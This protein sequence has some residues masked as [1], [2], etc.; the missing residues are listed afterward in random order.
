MKKCLPIYDDSL[1]FSR[2]AYGM[3][4]LAAFLIRDHWLILAVAVLM[5]LG[6]ISM[7]L[8]LFYQFHKFVFK[9]GTRAGMP[10]SREYGE[11]RFVSG[12]TALLLLA[13]FFWISSGINVDLAW[14]YL[15]VVTMLIFLA[16]FV[17]FCV[18]TLMYIFLKKLFAKTSD[19]K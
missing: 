9:K 1:K 4:V 5:I 19:G 15:L 2:A 14:I 6:T 17:G 12:A 18:A 10:N 13:G 7:R 3:L 11:L 16:C 8:N